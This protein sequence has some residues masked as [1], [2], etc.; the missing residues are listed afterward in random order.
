MKMKNKI[1]LLISI[2][3]LSFGANAQLDRSI[4]PKGGP[5]PKISLKTPK[6][7]KLKNGIKVLVVEDHKLPRVSYSL[8]ID[9]GPILEGDKAGVLSVISAMLGNGTTTIAKDDFNE[10]I[11][12]LGANVNI[13]FGLVLQVH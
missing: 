11:D 10:E 12:F 2:F 8:R 7:F 9:N 1:I 5:T 6:E 13:G 3:L 4:M